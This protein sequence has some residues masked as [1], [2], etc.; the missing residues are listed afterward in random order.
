MRVRSLAETVEEIA[1]VA[2]HMRQTLVEVLGNERGGT[3][4][5]LAWLE[6]RVREHIDGRLEGAVFVAEDEARLGYCMVRREGDFGQF[7][8]FY[9][10]PEHRRAGAA[11]ALVQAG[12]AWMRSL[13]LHLARTYTHPENV[14]LQR[15]LQKNG[16]S[17]TPVNRD[18]V[19][20]QRALA[21]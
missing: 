14:A 10:L 17:I 15:L 2:V 1:W 19:S 7:A 13:G 11:R 16:Y 9:V 21:P 18:F 6:N 5:D 4:Y 12:E 8:T 20:L 3:M